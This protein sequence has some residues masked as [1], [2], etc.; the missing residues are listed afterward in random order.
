MG[1]IWIDRK[2]LIAPLGMGLKDFIWDYMCTYIYIER[3]MDRERE[4]DKKRMREI[5]RERERERER[6]RR[7][8]WEVRPTHVVRIAQELSIRKNLQTT[9]TPV[10]MVALG[11][12]ICA[13]EIAFWLVCAGLLEHWVYDS[14]ILFSAVAYG[15]STLRIHKLSISE[16][17]IPWY[18]LWT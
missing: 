2:S 17:E 15:Q 3:E 11:D 9:H 10:Y 16:S 12:S 7:G 5:E 18:S 13:E 8:D 6:P 4:R 14:H 1:L